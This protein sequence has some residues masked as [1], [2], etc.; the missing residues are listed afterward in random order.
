[1]RLLQRKWRVD[2]AL[3]CPSC[4]ERVP[5]GAHGCA[6]CGADLGTVRAAAAH[7]QRRDV[8]NACEEE[9]PRR[10]RLLGDNAG[11]A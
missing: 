3:Q 9:R 2:D 6:M 5:V 1:M 11:V 7:A 8:E 10:V 4:G